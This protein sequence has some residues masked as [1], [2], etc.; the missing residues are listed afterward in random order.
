L[1]WVVRSN[2]PSK[3]ISKE[4]LF[5]Q[6]LVPGSCRTLVKGKMCLSKPGIDIPV[7]LIKTTNFYSK[8]I[9]N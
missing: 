1:R 7:H 4:T 9:D 8:S 2:L 6:L 5:D 3:I